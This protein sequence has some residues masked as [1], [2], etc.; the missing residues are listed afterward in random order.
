MNIPT[1]FHIYGDES[2]TGDTVVHAL[3]IVPVD[4]LEFAEETLAKVKRVF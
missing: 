3:V 4:V 1:K 2:I